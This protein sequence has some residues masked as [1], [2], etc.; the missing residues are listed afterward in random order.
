MFQVP[1]H[2]CGDSPT[3]IIGG[4]ELVLSTEIALRHF[5]TANAT[6]SS[7]ASCLTAEEIGGG[8]EEDTKTLFQSLR[9]LLLFHVN[10]S[11][12]KDVVVCIKTRSLAL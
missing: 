9:D 3:S 6:H 4:D 5:L 11:N 2:M 8:G 10:S 1:V 12:T 7:V